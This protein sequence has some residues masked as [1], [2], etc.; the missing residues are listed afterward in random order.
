MINTGIIHNTVNQNITFAFLNLTLR[1]HGTLRLYSLRCRWCW[2]GCQCL[3][4]SSVAGKCILECVTILWRNEYKDDRAVNA[5]CLSIFAHCF[6]AYH[7]FIANP[8]RY[9]SC[10][11]R[12]RIWPEVSLVFAWSL[13]KALG[14]CDPFQCSSN[15]TSKLICAVTCNTAIICSDTRA[16]ALKVR[17]PFGTF[18]RLQAGFIAYLQQLTT[19]LQP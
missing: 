1:F 8:Y 17:F 9:V 10:I 11:Q 4:C 2:A 6:F 7:P 12:R 3:I 13:T 5:C 15:S 14:K 19:L 18:T 16:A